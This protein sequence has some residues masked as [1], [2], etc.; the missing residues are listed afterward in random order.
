MN[1]YI[2]Q[3]A[4]AFGN[5]DRIEITEDIPQE[6]IDFLKES[7]REWQNAQRKERYH[8]PYSLDALVYEGID[9]ADPD[10]P[11]TIYIG[12]ED[13][14]EN[15]TEDERTE[16]YLAALTEV[17][18][19]RMRM[20]SKQMTYRDIAEI[21]GTDE[22]SIRDSVQAAHRKLQKKFPNFF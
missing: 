7:E 12:Y 15:G 11:E 1:N 3:G 14:E 16:K 4:D 8:T 17:Q 6:V 21:E 13:D 9:Y 22:S 20:R 18:R 5:V 2:I 10:T 19:R